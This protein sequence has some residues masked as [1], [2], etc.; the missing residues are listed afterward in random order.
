MVEV[1]GTTRSAFIARGALAA[2]ALYGAGAVAPLVERALAKGPTD[3]L[4]ILDFA[5]GLETVE[6]AFYE[7]ALAVKGLSGDVKKALQ[8]IAEHEQAHAQQLKRT[9]EQLGATAS[10][11]PKTS[12]PGLGGQDAMLR[13]AVQLEETGIAAYNGA[14]ILIE[15]DDLLSAAGSIVQVEARHAG[16]LREL[17]GQD[18]AP[19]AFDKGVS[20]DVTTRKIRPFLVKGGK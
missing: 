11:A 15:S 7:K 16:A 1:R 13:L 14:A 20:P 4:Q 12:F 10:P 6:V 5:L 9:L 17:A 19:A 18:P 3:D 2:G 8:E